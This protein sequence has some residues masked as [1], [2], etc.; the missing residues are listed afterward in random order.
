[1]KFN[2]IKSKVVVSRWNLVISIG[3]VC[4]VFVSVS[5]QF[6][7]DKRI[8]GI[9]LG[10]AAEGA[11]VTIV[12]DGGL[13]DYEAFRR[14]ER[15]YVRIP[16]AEFSTTQPTFHGDGFDDV[17]V[18]KVG[19]SV[20]ISFKLQPGASARV[21]QRGNH[22]DVIFTSIVRSQRSNTASTNN[23]ARVANITAG[24]ANPVNPERQR[25]AA[26]PAPSDAQFSRERVVTERPIVRR[27]A[28]HV[29]DGS[30][31]ANARE[32]NP[33][34]SAAP[35]PVTSASPTPPNSSAWTNNPVTAGTPAT[36]T[37]RSDGFSTNSSSTQKQGQTVTNWFADKRKTALLVGLIAAAV[38]ALA[39]FLY[40]RPR[41]TV[42]ANR[43][44]PA[45]SQP[46]YST[47]VEHDILR[48][49]PLGGEDR[50]APEPANVFAESR[51]K[52]TDWRQQPTE[53][54]HAAVEGSPA[55]GS[56]ISTPVNAAIVAN[57]ETSREDR[58]VFEL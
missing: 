12:S 21:D 24:G 45:L 35:Q 30:S 13:N 8:T 51:D 19:D 38:A 46:K 43:V 47:D 26:G 11:R 53:P 44:K 29:T 14:G 36:S 37:S 57:G 34:A 33:I 55:N 56:R 3:V 42:P 17:R 41:K 23:R 18:Q 1:M 7:S 58:E 49:E 5:A 9:Q 10:S 31:T 20:V 4:L 22:L 28:K 39:F 16:L 48:P 32:A 40:R 2:S 27:S 6:K 25:D 50:I 52:V 54:V 15:F